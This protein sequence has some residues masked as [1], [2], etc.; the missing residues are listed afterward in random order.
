MIITIKSISEE[1]K[2]DGKPK[3][4]TNSYDSVILNGK[5]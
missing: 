2:E 5:R 4:L 3:H 1:L